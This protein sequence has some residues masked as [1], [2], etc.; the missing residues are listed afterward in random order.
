MDTLP[1]GL[2]WVYDLVR[3]YGG[4]RAIRSGGYHMAYDFFNTRD[5]PRVIG[6]SDE[7]GSCTQLGGTA[8]QI[9]L[10]ESGGFFLG[11]LPS[12][13]SKKLEESILLPMLP[14]SE[15]EFDLDSYTRGLAATI[16]LTEP[17]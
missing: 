3:Q 4:I 5:D 15:D 16:E 8:I 10:P 2:F 13:K 11:S 1:R 12:V 9:I 7:T 14:P 17:L 6:L